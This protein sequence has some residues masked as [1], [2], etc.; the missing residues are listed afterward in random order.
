MRL[1]AVLPNG[2]RTSLLWIRDWD[3][4]WQEFYA[5]KEPVT[6]PAGTRLEATI[7]Y[8][9][10]SDNPRNPHSPP[11]RVQWGLDSSDEMGTIG[12]LLELPDPTDLPRVREALDARTQS[13]IQA[14]VADGTVQR[15]LA[16]QAALGGR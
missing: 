1:E 16:Q 12:A 14:G 13:A 7:T 5:F 3:F 4:N 9:N 11:R 2:V 15:Y 6:L 8:D 10:S